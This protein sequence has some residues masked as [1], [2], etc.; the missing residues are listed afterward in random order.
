MDNYQTRL[1]ADAFAVPPGKINEEHV[2]QARGLLDKFKVVQCL[3][4]LADEFETLFSVLQW[5]LRLR[6]YIGSK[7]NHLSMHKL[8][9]TD[10][11]KSWL[12]YINRHDYKLYSEYWNSTHRTA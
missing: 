11:E 3:E 8:Q 10:A 2:R 1:L 12:R 5:P 7:K 9:F 6:E 4:D